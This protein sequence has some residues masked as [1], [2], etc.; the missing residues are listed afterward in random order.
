V[1][2]HSLCAHAPHSLRAPI[3][4][5]LRA[6]ALFV[7][8][9]AAAGCRTGAE[10]SAGSDASST[11]AAPAATAVAAPAADAPAA[12]APAADAPSAD[13]P[14]DPGALYAQCRE[15][16]EGPEA[17][18]EC[19]AD[20]DCAAGGCSGEICAPAHALDGVMGSCEV[21]PCFS[22]LDRCGCV[23]GRCA[24]SVKA[25]A[26]ARPTIQLPDKAGG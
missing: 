16:V 13:A 22:V 5:P 10:N 19:S 4:G 11:N 21:L 18:G 24:W 1:N 3:Q 23:E 25:D 14:V 8:V 26:R 12:D 6:T 17:D 7:L 20:A 9:V 2:D 15:R